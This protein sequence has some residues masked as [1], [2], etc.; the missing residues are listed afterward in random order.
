MAVIQ[1]YLEILFIQ[2]QGDNF[3]MVGVFN[4]QPILQTQH[5]LAVRLTLQHLLPTLFPFPDQALAL[6]TLALVDLD[7]KEVVIGMEYANLGKHVPIALLTAHATTVNIATEKSCAIWDNAFRANRLVIHLQKCAMRMKEGVWPS[8]TLMDFVTVLKIVLR[9]QVI[10]LVMMTCFV[11]VK[12]D[13]TQQLLRVSL[14]YLRVL[15]EHNVMKFL[16]IVSKVVTLMAGVICLLKI[17]QRAL[18]VFARMASIATVK[19]FVKMASATRLY[20]NRA[21][22]DMKFVMKTWTVVKLRATMINNVMMS[23]ILQTLVLKTVHHV[24]QTAHAQTESFAMVK[25]SATLVWQSVCQEIPQI[26]TTMYAMSGIKSG[27]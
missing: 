26:L 5:I 4:N 10:V 19:S 8:V 21:F 3:Q 6:V 14:A 13:V 15:K 24:L 9:V 12:S 1:L 20:R 18:I 27:H 22:R 11:M 2:I 16:W 17:V 23:S 25:N 7:N